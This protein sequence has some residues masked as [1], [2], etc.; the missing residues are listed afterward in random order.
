MLATLAI[1]IWHFY[2]VHFNPDRFP[3][4]LLWWHGRMSE[5]EMKE[6]HPSS[7][8]KSWR[9]APGSRRRSPTDDGETQEWWESMGE[10]PAGRVVVAVVVGLLVVINGAFFVTAYFP[11]SCRA[12][13]Y[14]DPY[15]DQ[16]KASA[17]A[18]VSCI[19]CHSFSPVFITVTTLKYWT[20]LYNPRPR[21]DVKDAACLASG[22]AGRIEKG[23][24]ARGTSP[25][26]TR[27]T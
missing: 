2:N 7:W 5:H 10:P 12:C 19:K 24:R 11:G 25:S 16:W 15:V 1:V 9:G 22:Y 6:E 3:G 18:G 14:M 21:A 27:T 8:R 23:R 17:H 4:T 13:H 26:T 20:G